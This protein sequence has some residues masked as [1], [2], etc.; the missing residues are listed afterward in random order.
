[1]ENQGYVV[2]YEKLFE[3]DLIF[4]II[5]KTFLFCTRAV[6]QT[7]ENNFFLIFDFFFIFLIFYNFLYFFNF[8]LL[9]DFF[10]I[11]LI[12]YNFSYFFKFF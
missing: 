7:L 5:L 10:F 1:M 3:N 9:F 11:F 8:F 4:F 12:F 6:G 2:L